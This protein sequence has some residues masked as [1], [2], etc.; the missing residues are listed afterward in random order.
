[1]ETNVSVS[2][3]WWLKSR[4]SP[5]R[6]VVIEEVRVGCAGVCAPVVVVVVVVVAFLVELE[7]ELALASQAG[8]RRDSTLDAS[9]VAER[10]MAS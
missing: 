7:L 9:I 3:V 1:M 8:G 4:S 2:K 6:K 5:S 10:V